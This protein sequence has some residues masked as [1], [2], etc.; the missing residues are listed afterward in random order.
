[1][2]LHE[3]TREEYLALP[4]DSRPHLFRDR[5]PSNAT[6][7]GSRNQP[8][9]RCTECRSA[10]A[11]AV[12]KNRQVVRVEPVSVTDS[13]VPLASPEV[14]V[15][16]PQIAQEAA[17]AAGAEPSD[18]EPAQAVY[19]APG[20]LDSEALAVRM[21]KLA[22]EVAERHTGR[23]PDWMLQRNEIARRYGVPADVAS[24]AMRLTKDS[25]GVSSALNGGRGGVALLKSPRV[26]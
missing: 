5:E 17:T 2:D 9:C 23:L 6:Y 25:I 19:S 3:L 11:A 14:P 13:P 15:S 20:Q 21:L 1:M 26:A 24:A 7:T 10:H 12:R 4:D 22:A 8:G 16:G 18:P